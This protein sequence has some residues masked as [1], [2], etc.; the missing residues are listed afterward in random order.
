MAGVVLIFCG[1][2][3]IGMVDNVLRPVLVGRDT[4]M[5]DY[6]VLISTLG[7]IE[8]FGFNGF[9]VGPVIAA[10]FITVSGHPDRDAAEAG[11]D[12]RGGPLGRLRG[13]RRGNRGTPSPAGASRS[14]PT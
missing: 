8:I 9:I 6:V 14:C 10:L 12:G 1:L 4:R 3:V 7:G 5:P 11:A 13:G 2:F